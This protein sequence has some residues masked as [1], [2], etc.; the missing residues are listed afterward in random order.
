MLKSKKVKSLKGALSNHQL[1]VLAAYLAGA[2]KSYADTED[3]AIRA[4]EIA[5][6]RFA[7]RKYPEQIN[8][9]TVR[10]RLWDAAKSDKGGY[11]IGSERDGW[12]LT[13][14]GLEFC[15]LNLRA[16][17]STSPRKDRL[18][19]REKSWIDHERIRMLAEP[20][21]RKL[22]MGNVAEI[23]PIEADRFFRIDEYVVGEARRIK[24][25]RMVEAFKSDPRLAEA[26][27]KIAA[28]LRER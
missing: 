17:K 11:L 7:W 6:G 13:E 3:I 5:P 24:I 15:K 12:L 20:A 27:N 10:K 18:S 1:V 8:I 23:S 21:Y 14:A 9:E 19:L 4:N 2:R 25:Q 28:M 26:V 16:L 22:S